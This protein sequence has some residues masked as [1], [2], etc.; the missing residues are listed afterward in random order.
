MST[1]EIVRMVSMPIVFWFLRS[2]GDSLN[3]VRNGVN[4]WCYVKKQER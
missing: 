4:I 3:N 2:F 1:R